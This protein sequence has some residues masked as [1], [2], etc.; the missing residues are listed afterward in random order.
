[1][2]L[3]LFGT[4][5]IQASV[6]HS[7]D[8]G[9]ATSL[10]QFPT[11][12]RDSRYELK[13]LKVFNLK[14][15]VRLQTLSVRFTGSPGTMV[16]HVWRDI[17]STVRPY[18]PFRH[19][20][21][22]VIPPIRVEVSKS[23]MNTWVQIPLGSALIRNPQK[24]FIGAFVKEGGPR[25][26]EDRA[27]GA[28]ERSLLEIHDAK[29]KG[30]QDVQLFK[31]DGDYL[32]RLEVKPV[33]R[34]TDRLFRDAT[35]EMGLPKLDAGA[36][37]WGDVNGDGWEDLLVS[38]RRLFANRGGKRFDEITAEAGLTGT[39][40]HFGLFG[41]IDNDGDLDLWVGK[42]SR[43]AT[44]TLYINQGGRF[45]AVKTNAPAD[46]LNSF[47]G[48][49]LD[50]DADGLLDLF[51]AN[52]WSWQAGDPYEPDALWRNQ[53]KAG[54]RDVTRP[55]GMEGGTSARF[56]RA[57]TSADLNDDGRPE[58]FVGTFRLLPDRLW[59]FTARQAKD[60][61][62]SLGVAA[63]P[64]PTRLPGTGH[65]LGANVV[66]FNNDGRLDIFVANL[67]HPDWRGYT[68]SNESWMFRG[69]SGLRFER[70]P[71]SRL[72]IHYE[73]T[74]SDPCF[75]DF[76]NDGRQDVFINSLYHS[77][78]FYLGAEN[79]FQD[80]TLLSGISAK[81]ATASA[82]CD[83]DHDGRLDIAV[84]DKTEGMRLYRNMT[85]KR[86]WL[87]LR[88]VGSKAN[89]ASIGGT[90]RLKIGKRTLTRVVTSGKGM[91]NSD[92]LILHFGLG[93]SKQVD[94]L[95]IVWPGGQKQKLPHLGT[96]RRVA[97]EQQ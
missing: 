13:Q 5:A 64:S 81:L 96:D 77:A 3:L 10:A 19:F 92:S 79:G 9:R 4:L 56:S 75:G 26:G 93:S 22:D 72:G 31:A 36:I 63:G 82:S 85:P 15:P 2:L 6:T 14:E 32:V 30:R 87:E 50:Y 71:A 8:D 7:D 76:D 44:D 33:R 58:L 24:V 70:I 34:S 57:A 51:I 60:L 55:M 66:D 39:Q 49:W 38:G 61:A 54:F 43:S 46:H 88:L 52:G 65:A 80:Q 59:S 21:W 28:P 40:G 78:N 27:N 94:R 11:E 23:R 29:N 95:E 73:E 35:K 42:R 1:M 53:G 25:F 47:A 97:V 48:C 90:V 17:D 12:F 41:D 86:H 37:S 18:I 62:P 74:P 45:R 67:M 68:Q 20:E 83:F 84:A 91:G 89:R 16:I 69:S